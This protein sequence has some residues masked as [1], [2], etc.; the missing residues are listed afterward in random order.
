MLLEALRVMTSLAFA[1]K[2]VLGTK[3]NISRIKDI[4]ADTI[5]DN[6]FFPINYPFPYL[7]VQLQIYDALQ[8]SIMSLQESSLYPLLS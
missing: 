7:R 1:F 2:D 6:F 3:R 8:Y 4:I 5:T